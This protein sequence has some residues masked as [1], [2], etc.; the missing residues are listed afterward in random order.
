MQISD[1]RI[2]EFRR[3]YKEAYGE[4]IDVGESRLMALRLIIL[5]RLLMQLS[6]DER[7][8]GPQV[9]RAQSSPEVS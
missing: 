3:I 4:E 9:S 1:E 5:Y 8:L 7:G 2:D 6:P